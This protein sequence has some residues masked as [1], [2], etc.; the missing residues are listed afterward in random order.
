M[1]Y[2]ISVLLVV[3]VHVYSEDKEVQVPMASEGLNGSTYLTGDGH[4]QTLLIIPA[5]RRTAT[6]MR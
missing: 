6:T 1:K 4:H 3:S 5:E 2:L